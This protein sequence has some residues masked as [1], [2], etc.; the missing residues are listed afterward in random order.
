MYCPRLLLFR[1]EFDFESSTEDHVSEWF[2]Q[3]F[4]NVHVK[5]HGVAQEFC[6]VLYKQKM[7]EYGIFH[8]FLIS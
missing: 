1:E 4:K 3:N 2:C 5:K 8:I 6:T 7:S